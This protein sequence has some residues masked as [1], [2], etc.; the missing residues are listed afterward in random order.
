MLARLS[1]RIRHYA[2]I[3]IALHGSAGDHRL[4]PVDSCHPAN[5]TAGPDVDQ[6]EMARTRTLGLAIFHF[7]CTTD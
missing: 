4:A 5:E 1:W 3:A 7:R 6:G 2:S